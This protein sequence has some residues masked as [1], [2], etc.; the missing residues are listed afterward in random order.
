MRYVIKEGVEAIY[1]QDKVVYYADH[2]HCN[3]INII[4]VEKGNVWLTNEEEKIY[5][6]ERDIFSVMPFCL[7]SINS[8]TRCDLL[9]ISIP[10]ELLKSNKDI[11]GECIEGILAELGI[12]SLS[13]DVFKQ[14]IYGTVLNEDFFNNVNEK[15]EWITTLNDSSNLQEMAQRNNYSKY[16][17]IRK[18]KQDVRITP[19]KLRKVRLIRKAQTMLRNGLTIKEVIRKLDFY[20]QSHFIKQFKLV[21]G[22]TPTEYIDAVK[23][24]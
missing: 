8:K 7:H 14:Q 1:M 5:L 10:I 16:H 6:G 18:F 13:I 15:N 21:V 4:V 17:F 2:I 23:R 19:C 20:D 12:R 3:S 9:M 24:N 11:V 22:M